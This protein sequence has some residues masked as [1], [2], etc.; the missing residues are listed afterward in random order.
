MSE[1]GAKL[2]DYLST[3]QG[4]RV[5]LRDLKTYLGIANGS[6][7]EA[8]LRSLMSR[9]MV[10]RKIVSPSGWNDGTYKVVK[11]VKP[12]Q[13]YG[14]GRERRPPF[15]LVFP[16]DYDTRMQ[17]DF[18]NDVVVREGDLILISGMSNFGKTLLCLS[19]CGENIDQRPVLMGNEYTALDDEPAERFMNRLDD[20]SDI[21]PLGWVNWVDEAGMDKFT[22]LPVREDYAEHIVRDRINIIDWLNLSGEYY[23]ISPVMEAIKKAL[24]RGICI[25]AIQKNEGNTAGR[26]GAPSKDFADLELLIDRVGKTDV[27][28]TVGKCKESTKPITGNTYSYG[29][30]RGIKIINFREVKTCPEC[31]GQGFTKRGKCEECY[32]NKFVDK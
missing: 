30:Q 28:L 24:G 23:M 26:G 18:A 5:T 19:F 1:L 16:K 29:I 22:L 31:N 15:E 4:K 27:L 17:M 13:V 3:A 21:N 2:M 11:Q 25:I 12:V 32:G 9:T 8:T 14:I 10:E 20:M 6:K 7:E